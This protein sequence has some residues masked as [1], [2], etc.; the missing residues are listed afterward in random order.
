MKLKTKK[1]V[2]EVKSMKP[3]ANETKSL[4]L[5]KINEIDKPLARQ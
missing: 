4:L 5:E 3:K 1:K 2:N